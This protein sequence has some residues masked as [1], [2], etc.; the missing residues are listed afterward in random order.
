MALRRALGLALAA[1]LAPGCITAE[2]TE[3]NAVPLERVAQIRPGETTRDE[4]LAWFG[5]PE[6]FTDPGELRRLLEET[7]VL[8]EE[9]LDLPFADILVFELTKAKLRGLVL[10]V[11]NRFEVRAASDRLVIFFDE[12]DRVAHYGFREGT[13]ALR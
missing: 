3:G 5:A 1:S 13:D 11:Y 2:L 8:P 4:I 7:E 6:S 10:L 12:Q 9:V